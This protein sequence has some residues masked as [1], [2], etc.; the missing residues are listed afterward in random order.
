MSSMSVNF[1]AV[2]YG[3]WW[4]SF[5]RNFATNESACAVGAAHLSAAN[6]AKWACCHPVVTARN[7]RDLLQNPMFEA[8]TGQARQSRWRRP[9][10]R[11]RW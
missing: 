1:G 9:S 6:L 3:H 8:I 7:V 5:V 4:P 10:A 2:G 11:D